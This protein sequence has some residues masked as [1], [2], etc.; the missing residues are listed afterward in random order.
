MVSHFNLDVLDYSLT[1]LTIL[2]YLLAIIFSSH[3]N[4]LSLSLPILVLLY[5]KVPVHFKISLIFTL[6][7]DSLFDF[8][9][10]FNLFKFFGKPFHC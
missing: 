5:L 4:Y 8:T 6:F 10:F 2:M 3:V 7:Y 9:F 1:G